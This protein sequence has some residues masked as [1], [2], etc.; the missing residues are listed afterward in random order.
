MDTHKF[1]PHAARQ[2]LVPLI[3]VHLDQPE[4]E[5]HFGRSRHVDD[6]ASIATGKRQ[7]AKQVLGEAL[8]FGYGE[9]A[10][11]SEKHAKVGEI[12]VR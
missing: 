9:V 3:Q 2:Y 6:R 7:F 11:V 4:S 12:W 10:Q 8:F 1:G 5:L